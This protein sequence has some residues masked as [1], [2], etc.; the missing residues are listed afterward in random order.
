MELYSY[1]KYKGY[2]LFVEV[3]ETGNDEYPYVYEGVAQHNGTNI[4]HSK[5]YISGDKAEQILME[6]IDSE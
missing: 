2:H 1:N 3:Y 6:K 4:D 5:S